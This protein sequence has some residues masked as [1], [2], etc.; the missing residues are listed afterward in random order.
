MRR[1][2]I[3]VVGASGCLFD[4]AETE[5][6][7][8]NTNADCANGLHCVEW[9]CG[10]P[11]AADTSEGGS[12][13]SDSSSDESSAPTDD[14]NDGANEACEPADTRC[15]DDDTVR[16][17]LD[18]GKLQTIGCP[19]VCGEATPALGCHDSSEGEQCYC[20]FERQPC[21]GD[22]VL[23]CNGGNQLG[24][25]ENGWAEIHDCDEICVG[26]GYDGASSCGPGDTND[27][28]FCD[29][30]C[31]EAAQRC[32]NDHEIAGCWGGTWYT[33]S[34]AQI[35]ADNGYAG[36]LGCLVYPGD[37]SGCGCIE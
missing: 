15:I 9:V 31:T 35:C 37:D 29:E 21:T 16:A 32:V 7:P 3:L 18:D 26:A 24:M 20:A 6:L 27:V 23:D 5:G 19:G 25:C 33:E 2:T 13:E 4:G 10:G 12:D 22:G 1:W 30:F 8:C 17:C 36:S 11:T 34:C 28:C 14:E